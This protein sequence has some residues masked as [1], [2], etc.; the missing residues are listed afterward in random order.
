MK[1]NEF[2]YRLDESTKRLIEFSQARVKNTISKN[3][4]YIVEPSSRENSTHLNGNERKKLT[5]INKLAGQ[6]LNLEQ[7]VDTLNYDG[8]VPLWINCE[9]D[10]STKTKTTIKLLCSR[11]YRGVEHLNSKADKFPPFHPLLS[12]PP[13]R[14]DGVKFNINWKHQTLKRK[15]YAWTSN[16][17]RR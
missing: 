6:P 12:L 3:V 15:W 7:V 2:K 9:I 17:Q 14:I 13:W 10:R 11:R 1:K 16:W 4:E 8:L 5:E